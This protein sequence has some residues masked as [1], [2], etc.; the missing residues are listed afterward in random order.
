MEITYEL[1]Q[2]DF[3]E[4]F[5][6]HRNRRPF[7]KWARRTVA[8]V[9]ILAS[10]LALFGSIRTGNTR[11]LLPFFGLVAMWLLFLAGAPTWWSARRQF[12]RQPGAHGA[13]TVLFDAI[14]AHWQWNGGSSD[15][16][17]KNYV[18]SVEGKNQVLLYT[19]PACFNIIPKRALGKEGLAEVLTLLKQRIPSGN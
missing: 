13:R 9:M 11:T 3:T 19:S 18:R 6:A 17:W 14:G 2:K 16:E 8:W 1:T 12:L 4:S 7:V 10:A 15:V 5:N